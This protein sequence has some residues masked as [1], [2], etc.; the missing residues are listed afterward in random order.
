MWTTSPDLGCNPS[1]QEE[2]PGRRGWDD[3]Q[4]SLHPVY[5]GSNGAMGKKGL[6]GNC[7]IVQ[8]NAPPHAA[9]DTPQFLDQH[10]VEVMDWPSMGP[11]MNPI[12]HVWDQISIW[13]QD[14]ERPPCNL[15]ES[16]QA[17]RQ[18]WRAVR[19]RRVRTLAESMPHHV[20]AVLAAR[21]G[22]ARY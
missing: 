8:D 16:R 9:R 13:I 21:G 3:D 18:T 10:D 5:E 4:A 2:Q 20:Q 11:D 12:E 14:M 6:R 7:A 19:P 1:W 22:H 15:A 17:V